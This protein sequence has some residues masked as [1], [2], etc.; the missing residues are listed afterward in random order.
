MSLIRRIDIE[1]MLKTKPYEF[2]RPKDEFDVTEYY[3]AEQIVEKYKVNAV[4]TYTRQNNLPKS[5]SASHHSIKVYLFS[6]IL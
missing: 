4:W 1:L 2:L 3:T 6:G 5:E